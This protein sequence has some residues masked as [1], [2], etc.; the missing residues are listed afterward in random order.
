MTSPN[1]DS[2]SLREQCLTLIDQIIQT[3]LK[4]QIRSKEQ[5]YQLLVDNLS[6]GTGEIFERCLDERVS[7]IRHQLNTQTD[8]LK[9]AKATR[10]LRALQTIQDVWERWQKEN[11]AVVVRDRGVQQI[12]TAPVGERLTVLLQILDLNQPHGLNRDQ[13]RQLAQSLNQTAASSTDSD[14]VTELQ[15]VAAGLMRGLE[16]FSAL[17]PYIISWI[18]D[19]SSAVIGFE[20]IPGQRG[21]WMLWAQQ[22]KSPLP[23]Q[24]FQ[25]QA[26]DQSAIAL[27]AQQQTADLSAWV[28]LVVILRG[29]QQALVAWFDKQP[30]S[31]KWGKQLSCAT[32]VTFAILWSQLSN[33]LNQAQNLGA[34][35]RHQ[36][37]KACFQITLQILRTFAQRPDFP[38]YGGLFA[39][40]TGNSLRD[41]LTYLDEPLRQAEGTQEK[42]RILTLLGYSQQMLGQSER[43]I[44]FHQEALNIARQ[45]HDQLCEIA[46]FNHLSRIHIA[47]KN[48][49]AA[50]TYSQ[51][52]L[53]LARQIGDRLGEAN[54]LANLGYSEVLATQAR[55]QMELEVYEGSI[56]HLNQGLNLAERL[57]DRQSQALCY[58]SLGIA[59]LIT[60]QPSTAIPYLENGIESA[61]FAGDL[62]LQGRNWS[63]LAEAYY[64]LNQP[65][66]AIYSGSL[67]MYLLE[68]IAAN[69]WRQAA[70]LLIILQGQLGV[71]AF[72]QL[73]NQFRS[74]FVAAIGVDG[75][76]YLPQLLEQYRRSP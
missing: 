53:I 76:D 46:N 22:V 49:E 37:A 68:Q 40:F 52:A 8:E 25:R 57:G 35:D 20:G 66:K 51:R 72:Q 67:G 55:E 29:L 42:G 30:Y 48:Y 73:L 2:T 12:L 62:Y 4:G 59:Y 74:R 54:G 15:E 71:E 14:Q 27:I 13:I 64:N 41:T 28:E 11:Q 3:T 26:L 70:G 63:Y 38:L 39:S 43:A 69:E 10:Q 9:Q 33:G 5:V 32:L 61:Q 21:P 24:L 19:Q 58:N 6:P 16:S 17:E 65:D 18:Y 23:Q 34:G 31:I 50:I 44:S 36:L 1:P 7:T 60:G 45:A 56:E 47:Q 75:F